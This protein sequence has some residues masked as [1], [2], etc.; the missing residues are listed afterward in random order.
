MAGRSSQGLSLHSRR[1]CRK[2][3]AAGLRGRQSDQGGALRRG[4]WACRSARD[5]R[6]RLAVG[7]IPSL[8]IACGAAAA[9]LGG[10]VISAVTSAAGSVI[11]DFL[12]AQF[13]RIEAMSNADWFVWSNTRVFW[14]SFGSI[15]DTTIDP[16]LVD[17][18]VN[19]FHHD[20]VRIGVEWSNVPLGQG[21]TF[22]SAKDGGG[23]ASAPKQSFQLGTPEERTLVGQPGE[24]TLI[25]VAGTHVIRAGRGNDLIEGGPG[26]KVIIG[27]HGSDTIYAGRG[28][29][30]LHGGTG[31]NILLGG[32][33]HDIL[34]GGPGTDTIVDTSG[35]ALVRTGTDNGPGV[36]FVN[37]RDGRGGD[38]VICG[39]RRTSVIVDAS[40]RVIGPC[41][42]VI[43]SGPILRLPH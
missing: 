2:S 13:N 35:S 28:D 27:G 36:D 20:E 14:D 8:G 38:T 24:D 15:T 25:G 26:K 23:G 16:S 31:N 33:G 22:F 39:S 4:G 34:N 21:P 29:Q 5:Q 11:K 37:V 30:L 9:I 43:R 17:P 1:D 7:G 12:E 42:Q 40:D 10:A 41:G 3:T 19:P 32:R 6:N 18:N